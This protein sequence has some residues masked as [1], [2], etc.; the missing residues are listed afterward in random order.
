M[1]SLDTNAMIAAL[2]LMAGAVVAKMVTTYLIKRMMIHIAM[3]DQTKQRILGELK[4]VQSQRKVAEQNKAMLTQKKEKIQK[5]ID[6]LTK[7]LNEM[8]EARAQQ[9]QRREAMHR[10]LTE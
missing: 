1:E 9:Q 4:V 3:V 10:S 5:Q 8:E 2:L 6:R 7:T